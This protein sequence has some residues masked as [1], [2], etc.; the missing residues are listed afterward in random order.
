VFAMHQN[1]VMH[2]GKHLCS[3]LHTRVCHSQM[4]RAMMI[5]TRRNNGSGCAQC[6]RQNCPFATIGMD[7]NWSRESVIDWWRDRS[8]DFVH[9]FKVTS[10]GPWGFV[11][12]AL[13]VRTILQE[14]DHKQGSTIQKELMPLTAFPVAAGGQPG[15]TMMPGIQKHHDSSEVPLCSKYDSW[16]C[17]IDQ[18]RKFD[19]AEKRKVGQKTFWQYRTGKRGGGNW[20]LM[21]EKTTKL[22]EDAFVQNGIEFTLHSDD[23]WKYKYN[24]IEMTQTS[25][26]PNEEHAPK[27]RNV[28]RV[29]DVESV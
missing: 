3:R 13:T 25:I 27:T 29:H 1:H 20:A 7:H 8:Q 15:N 23:G 12:E 16:D 21:D 11:I 6:R 2:L 28:R 5:D 18:D 19:V 17:L 10:E 24:F 26:P 14:I 9:D 4:E 22:L